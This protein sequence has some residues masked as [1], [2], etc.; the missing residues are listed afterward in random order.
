MFPNSHVRNI[1]TNEKSKHF[2]ARY[3]INQSSNS[4]YQQNIHFCG[5]NVHIIMEVQTSYQ[6]KIPTWQHRFF[7]RIGW[8]KI[9]NWYLQGR[10]L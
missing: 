9:Y 7:D 2:G 4:Q 10:R 6:L 5:S 8:T 1:R 3:H